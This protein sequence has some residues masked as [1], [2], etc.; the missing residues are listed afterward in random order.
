MKNKTILIIGGSGE[1]ANS[2]INNLKIDNKIIIAS[3]K[4]KGL[5]SFNDLLN[6]HH[7]DLSNKNSIQSFFEHLKNHH[8]FLDVVIFNSSI[9]S[10]NPLIEESEEKIQQILNINIQGCMLVN[11]YSLPLLKD[12]GVI[13]NISSVFGSIGFPY[14]S[15]YSASKAAIKNFSEAL[16][17]E[18]Q[19]TGKNVLYFQPRAINTNMNSENI[20]QMNKELKSTIDEPDF[21]AATLI[22]Y[23]NNRQS[24]IPFYPEKLFSIINFI[25]P[26][27]INNDFKKKIIT[28]KKYWRNTK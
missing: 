4:F 3:S 22:K 7:L 12:K 26:F 20:L 9:N 15:V 2:I 21:V 16:N 19:N 5:N 27:V 25:F 6:Y 13:C 11:K 14:F 23:I 17:R 8:I 10:F 28:I 1:F 24:G 18:I